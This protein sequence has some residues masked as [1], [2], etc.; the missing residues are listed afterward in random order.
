MKKKFDPV[1]NINEVQIF[2]VNHT[3]QWKMAD[4]IWRDITR[5]IVGYAHISKPLY[6]VCVLMYCTIKA[7]ILLLFYY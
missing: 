4:V 1:M 6:S 3:P 5:V 2:R 7:V